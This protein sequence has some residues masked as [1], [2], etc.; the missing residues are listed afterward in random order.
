MADI[1]P[2]V[3]SLCIVVQSSV[4]SL[5]G[6][7]QSEPILFRGCGRIVQLIFPG[8]CFTSLHRR[9]VTDFCQ[10]SGS[11]LSRS[12]YSDSKQPFDL[13]VELNSQLE[14]AGTHHVA[15]SRS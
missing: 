1:F 4:F 14:I 10:Q 11:V 5:V 15:L 12:L 6:L 8:R 3:M 7:V 9:D 13:F 2:L